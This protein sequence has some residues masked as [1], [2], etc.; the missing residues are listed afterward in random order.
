MTSNIA[1]KEAN[2]STA[3]IIFAHRD[4]EHFAFQ[5]VTAR[6][7]VN[8][9]YVRDA[10]LRGWYNAGIDPSVPDISS[11]A[12]ELRRLVSDLRVD[13]LL[14]MGSSMGGY[15]AI[16]FG[17]MLSAE[18][19]LAFNPQTLLD[20]AFPL[21]PPP[22]VDIH[23]PDL[24]LLMSRSPQTRVQIVIGEDDAVDTFHA[25]RVWGCGSLEVSTRPG[26]SHLVT[27]ELRQAGRLPDL[28]DAWVGTGL[29][30][31]FSSADYMIEAEF[32]EALVQ[33]VEHFF[34][35]DYVASVPCLQSACDR[36]DRHLGLHHLL[37][38][39]LV[40][41]GQPAAAEPHLRHVWRE[42]RN[43]TETAHFLG[44]SLALQDRWPEAA[45]LFAYCA[46]H[47]P[48]YWPE[49]ADWLARC[50]SKSQSL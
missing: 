30:P 6:L 12:G 29:L 34:H 42:R 49:N 33:G 18:L 21:S 36:L 45:T 50:R 14:T 47:H 2:C 16:L 28:I 46:E 10:S 32:R 15:A 35:H 13:R 27:E 17:C 43:W 11:V 9:I 19:V 40:R 7:Q 24:S 39:A 1:V 3:L 25:A 26:A 5:G 41:I 22:G 48:A 4:A 44:I 20:R 37:G 8:R 38:E 23:E 31:A